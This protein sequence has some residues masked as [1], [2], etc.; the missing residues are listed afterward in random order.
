MKVL[1][2]CNKGFETMEFA[3][4]V[5]V[6]GWATNDYHYDIEVITCLLIT[7]QILQLYVNLRRQSITKEIKLTTKFI[8]SGL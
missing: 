5:D 8:F 2:F 1:L 7:F 6:M 4:F 3:P